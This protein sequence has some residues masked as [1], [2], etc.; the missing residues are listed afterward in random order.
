[1]GCEPRGHVEFRVRPAAEV[2]AP[3]D[4]APLPVE[5]VADRAIA[6]ELGHGHLDLGVRELARHLRLLEGGAGEVRLAAEVLEL[7]LGAGDQFGQ[8]LGGVEGGVVRGHLLLDPV[9]LEFE[10]LGGGPAAVRVVGEEA[11]HVG[12]PDLV[13]VRQRRPP[14]RGEGV[15]APVLEVGEDAGELDRLGVQEVASPGDGPVDQPRGIAGE[16]LDG[17]GELADLAERLFPQLGQLPGE[18]VGAAAQVA[19]HR[20][21]LGDLRDLVGDDRRPADEVEKGRGGGAAGKDDGGHEHGH[22]GPA[23]GGMDHGRIPCQLVGKRASLVNQIRSRWPARMVTSGRRLRK[24]RMT[25]W[26]L[27]AVPWLT[28]DWKP[29]KPPA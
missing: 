25:C 23:D 2:A 7:G 18:A 5:G 15:R 29:G 4:F 26:P 14:V 19:D 12:L 13:G 9:T 11:E 22:Q 1:M 16:L 28:P 3:L 20:D 10:R 21:G 6:G 8:R 24:R 27:A 17:L